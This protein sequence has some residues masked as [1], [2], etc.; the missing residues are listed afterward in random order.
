MGRGVL[1]RKLRI[2]W[3]EIELRNSWLLYINERKLFGI[4]W[5]FFNY[6][7]TWI[8]KRIHPR[9]NSTAIHPTPNS[10]SNCRR[11]PN[12]SAKLWL[13]DRVDPPHSFCIHS[14]VSSILLTGSTSPRPNSLLLQICMLMARLHIW[15]SMM[16]C[17][18]WRRYFLPGF[19]RRISNSQGWC[20]WCRCRETP[21]RTQ[22][23]PTWQ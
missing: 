10:N 8:S 4:I 11:R 22:I 2:R 7:L 12:I 15:H 21:S 23:V 13:L 16:R 9:R 20:W 1:W 14:L 6:H 3:W 19:W 5:S 18:Q 17:R